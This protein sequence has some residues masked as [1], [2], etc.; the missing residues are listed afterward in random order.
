MIVCL[1]QLHICL[2]ICKYLIKFYYLQD[3]L[4]VGT[5]KALTYCKF[6]LTFDI[7]HNL[8]HGMKI[9]MKIHTLTIDVDAIYSRRI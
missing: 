5:F 2:D 1:M 6:K 4:N 8:H 9:M 3:C 7:L